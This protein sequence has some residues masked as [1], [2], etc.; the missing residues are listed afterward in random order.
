LTYGIVTDEIIHQLKTIVGSDDILLNKETISEYAHDESSIEPYFPDVVVRVQNS[1]EVSQI[2]NLAKRERIPVTPRGG[3]TGLTGGSIPIYGGILISFEKMNKILELDEENLTLTVEPGV[4]IR[5]IHAYV[6]KYGLMYPPDPGQKSGV[7]AGNIATNAGGMRGVKYG[8]TRDFILGLEVVLPTGE[9]TFLGG[10]NVK[11]TTGYSLMNLIIGSEGT[12]AIITKAIL[13]LI[14]L[15]KTKVTLYASYKNFQDASRTVSEIIK[16]KIV[17]PAIEFIDQSSILVA[18]RYLGRAMPQS[19]APAYV[20]IRFDGNV[21]EAVNNDYEV[22]GEICIRN[23]ALDVLVA[24]TKESQEKLWEGRSCIIDAA[25]AESFIEV[26]DCVVPRNRIPELIEG[27]NDIAKKYAMECQNFG[28]AGDGNVHTN[29]LKKEM[30][31]EEWNK[32]LP[33]FLEEIY[34]LSVSLGGTISG[35]H[36]I[37]L[38]RKKFLTM[39]RD[40]VQIELMKGIKQIFDPKNILNPGKIFDM[41]NG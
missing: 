36:G 30:S 10:K 35:E 22:V 31:D 1:D 11:N 14:P 33:L 17:P 34:K 27:L 13:R 3:G 23:N 2:L 19:N 9:V 6:E 21:K 12:L 24:D 4:L 15:P 26:L 32:K 39:T 41:N 28:H 18:E 16:N 25:K 29:V 37:G 38:I 7:I 8:V 20:V 5:D 40:T